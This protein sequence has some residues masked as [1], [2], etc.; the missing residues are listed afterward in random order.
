MTMPRRCK[1]PVVEESEEE[2][3]MEIEENNGDSDGDGMMT[4]VTKIMRSKIM[5]RMMTAKTCPIQLHT[6]V[7]M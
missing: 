7:M 2:E 5:M 4:V 1:Q 3:Q 6:L